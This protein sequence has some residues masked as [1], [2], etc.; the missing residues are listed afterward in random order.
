MAKGDFVVFA[1][2]KLD[3]G[4]KIHNLSADSLMF[5]CIK[6]LANGGFDPSETDTDPRWG[7]GGGVNLSTSEVAAGGNYPAGGVALATVTWA[8][9][10]AEA[11][12]DSADVNIAIHAANPTNARW[13]IVY[14][15]TAA[16]KQAIGYVDFGGDID[17]TADD[18]DYIVDPVLG[19]FKAA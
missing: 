2:S 4:K 8:L 11:K 19:W 12:L 18:L 7:V 6:S 14:N 5:A 17:I 10:G 15:N 1:Q 16:G 13:A 9:T 3:R